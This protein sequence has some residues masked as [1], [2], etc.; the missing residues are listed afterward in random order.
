MARVA[1]GRLGV[2]VRLL[3]LERE[4]LD[5]RKRIRV[6]A[7]EQG[8]DKL[9]EVRAHAHAVL[10]HLAKVGERIRVHHGV[11]TAARSRWA[12]GTIDWESPQPTR[13]ESFLKVELKAAGLRRL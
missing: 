1:A 5:L 10:P 12:N 13:T 4:R 3:D 2:K 6:L 11:A 9:G 8:V 7:L